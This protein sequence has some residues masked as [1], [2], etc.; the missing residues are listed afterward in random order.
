M[1]SIIFL[2]VLILCSCTTLP[3]PFEEGEQTSPPRGCT[4][5]RDR[6]VD[7]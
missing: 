2:V 4:E 6:G 5:G 3:I 1:K 7:C